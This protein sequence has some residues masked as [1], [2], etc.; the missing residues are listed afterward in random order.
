VRRLTRRRP[1]PP[2]LALLA[3]LVL[4]AAA[5]GTAAGGASAATAG[6][7]PPWQVAQQVNGRL[8]EAQTA[9]ILGTRAEA[10]AEVDGA[11]RRYE[12]TL[13]PTVRAADPDADK[14]I[15]A[16]F[17]DARR[18]AAAGDEVRLA[19]ARGEIRAALFAGAFEV[20]L[21]AVQA[22]DAQTASAWLLLREFRTAT[23][24]TRPG[25][26]ATLAVRQLARRRVTPEEA[27][28]VVAKDL[29]DAY[30]A[31]LREL[32]DDA[33]RGDERALPNRRAEAAAQAAGY[34]AILLPR[35][36]Q[37]MGDARADRA[38]AAYGRM[39]RAALNGDGPAFRAAQ[40]DAVAALEGFTAAPFT[41]AEAARRAQQLLRFLALV[42]VEYGRGVKD[43]RV[44]LD[45]EIQE[46]DAFQ[47]GA[48]AA[49]KDLQATL[50]KRD[51]RTTERV[52]GQLDQLGAIVD[53][54]TRRTE[55]VTDSGAVDDLT[56]AV[57]DGL[58][59]VMPKAWQ[60]ETDESDYDLI[61][62][63]LD[64]MEA[65]VGAGQYQQ[66]EQ[67]RLEAYAFFEF[68]PERRLKAFDPGLALDVEGLIWFG[69]L[70]HEGLANLIDRRA[71]RRDV[72]ET[73]LA[74]DERLAD[75]A[76]TL[77][78]SAN[79]AQVVV[80][81]AILVFREGLEAVLIL[82][83]ITAS[84][85]GAK[86]RMRRPVLVG[87]GLGLL[88][89]LITWVLAQTI[90]T[91]LD[92]YGEK[93]E[94][95]V[96][97]VAIAVLLLITNWFFH[98]VYWSEWIGKFHR[99]RRRLE[100]WD[101]V[102]F[103]S[104]QVIGLILLGL[105]SVYREGFETVLFLQSL[106]LS[107][108]TATVVEG[109][110]LGLAMVLAVAVLTFALQRKLPYKK[111]LI[112]TGVMIGFV[113][114]VMVGQTARTMQGTGWLPITPLQFDP[115]YWASLWFGIYPTW[116]TVGA[117]VAAMAFVI[118]SYF[119][120]QEVRVKRPQRKARR[121]RA[122]TEAPAAAPPAAA[123]EPAGVGTRAPGEDAR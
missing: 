87:A 122:G 44:T 106:E 114:V 16:A 58:D 94:A 45:F 116:E 55:D 38:L 42:P 13:S 17:A 2:L 70:D 48:E 99:Q 4:A 43:G 76:A 32:L 111:M 82:A 108:G 75:S 104:A 7:A 39:A 1:L 77:G 20:T 19:G 3:A 11:R 15:D 21:D 123:P 118:G 34:F 109:A 49:F 35:Y 46:A 83:A 65:A 67:A 9:L 80:N 6:Q 53:E 14:T 62:L 63:T 64:R 37:E 103:L 25:G 41:D 24:F 110:G 85:V 84:F 113:L 18:A 97:I 112:V 86:R 81:S 105:T 91:S 79:K 101:R 88:A 5:G 12:R 31:R 71:S 52:A 68:G 10:T 36:V 90:L 57:E 40:A 27:R 59:A 54:A 26:D 66:A 102:G 72:H 93:L 96:G 117:Q 78:D 47:R 89:S 33:A 92:Q 107:A 22:G 98:K 28:A 121:R 69:A 115:P 74:L 119:L 51:P 50:A 73:R 100:R 95:V 61:A 8:F 23:R 30:Q 29:L 56:G 60:E 120:A